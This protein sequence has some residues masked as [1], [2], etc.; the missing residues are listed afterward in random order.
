[1]GGIIEN[2]K[3]SLKNFARSVEMSKGYKQGNIYVLLN[4]LQSNNQDLFISRFLRLMNAYI[5]KPYAA[6][7][8]ANFNELLPLTEESFKKIGYLI[9]SALMSIKTV[10]EV[11]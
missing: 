9:I 1:M 6:E 7:C 11:E 2:F 4:A 10:K 8:M 3:E 5:D